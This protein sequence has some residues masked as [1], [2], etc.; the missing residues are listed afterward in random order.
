MAAV[1]A[2]AVTISTG[3][4]AQPRDGGLE[5][6]R[7]EEAIAECNAD[8][9]CRRAVNRRKIDEARRQA[10]YEAKPLSEQALPWL[11]IIG[12]GWGIWIWAKKGMGR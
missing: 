5:E 9:E 7:R 11:A 8:P 6:S 12:V 3:S 4:H 2:I 1:A 10:E